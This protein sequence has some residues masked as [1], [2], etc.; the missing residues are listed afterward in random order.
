VQVRLADM[1]MSHMMMVA[2]LRWGPTCG[3]S[4]RPR[5]SPQA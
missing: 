3:W 4:P 2:W 5:P 1:G